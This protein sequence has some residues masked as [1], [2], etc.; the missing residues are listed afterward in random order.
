[1]LAVFGDIALAIGA[2]FEKYLANTLMMLSQASQTQIP[3]DDEE[4]V[5]YLNL[6]RESILEAYTG[7][8]QGEQ[9]CAFDFSRFAATGLNDGGKAF[10]MIPQLEGIF[11]FLQAV[12]RDSMRS[13]CD[14]DVVKA[15][16]GL[17]GDL[18]STLGR[19]A[20]PFVQRDFIQGLLKQ[21]IEDESMQQITQ[22]TQ[23]KIQE[24]RMG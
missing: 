8:I 7:V 1:M 16:I 21:G 2:N 24:L 17:V 20:H 4:L 9:L 6:L 18:V 11:D 15:S 3:E 22:W 19:E 10:L 23:G 12:Y 13:L 14:A 5:E